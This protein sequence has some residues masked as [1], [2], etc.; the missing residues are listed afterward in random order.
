MNKVEINEIEMPRNT[1]ESST[2]ILL[3]NVTNTITHLMLGA[4]AIGAITFA[5]AFSG[6]NTLSQHIYLCVTGV[7]TVYTHY[8]GYVPS[9][10]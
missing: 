6:Q 7:S 2:F 4:V 3:M 5:T 9:Y 10:V 1:G 8:M